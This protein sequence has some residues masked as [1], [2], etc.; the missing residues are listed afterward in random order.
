[1]TPSPFRNVF[2]A[3]LD[4]LKKAGR[5]RSLRTLDSGTA[6]VISVDGH[7][8]LLFASNDYLGLAAHPRMI[9]E[10][11]QALER[12]GTGMGASRLVAG[13]HRLHEQ[14]ENKVAALKKTE[15]A[16]LFSSGYLTHIGVIP[17]LVGPGDLIFSDNLNHA[18]LV[19]ACRL[20]RAEIVIYPHRQGDF[21]SDRLRRIP[22]R[23]DTRILIVT[24]GVFSMDGDLAPLP[25][26]QALAKT[27]EALV[28]VDDAHATGVLGPHGEGSTGHWRIDSKNL[29]TM[30]TFSKAL[31]ALGGFV[32]GSEITMDYLRNQAR[33]LF[34]STALPP[35]V[36]ASVGCALELLREEPGLLE[37]L[38]RNCAYFQ[39]G[40]QALGMPVPP[41]GIP[42]FPIIV[43]SE[44]RALGLAQALWERDIYIPAIRP[45]TVPPH[46]CRLRISLMATHT[47]EQLDILL[48]VLQGLL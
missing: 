32:A 6:P 43:G 33:T 35:A 2:Q 22:P 8:R 29:L 48:T 19:D 45:P 15:G 4:R 16:L 14:V 3:E 7:S 10:T 30:G 28:L 31:G 42:I 24:D 21:I 1:M 11:A 20:S 23:P 44:E 40:L 9:R 17:S 25:D 36:C 46:Q 34:Y 47:R 41:E 37:G 26:L 38:R 18:S 27:Y 12:Y 13:H 39:N 5:Y